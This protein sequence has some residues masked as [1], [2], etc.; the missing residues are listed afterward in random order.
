[1]VR[2]RIFTQ[3]GIGYRPLKEYATDEL[4]FITYK[5]KEAHKH[6]EGI[7]LRKDLHF[8]LH[9]NYG[10]YLTEKDFIFF[11]TAVRG[12]ERNLFEKT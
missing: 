9:K 4:N 3:C 1:M 5:L 6:I 12:M 11:K 10:K 2:D 7:P 8:L